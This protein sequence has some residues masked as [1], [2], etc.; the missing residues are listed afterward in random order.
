MQDV[1]AAAR[2][3]LPPILKGFGGHLCGRINLCWPAAGS[4][5][6]DMAIDWRIIL[7]GSAVRTETDHAADEMRQA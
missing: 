1:A 2:R 7:G 4:P 5:M 6:K 3:P